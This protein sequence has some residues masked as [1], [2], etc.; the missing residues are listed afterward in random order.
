[1]RMTP[2]DVQ[3]HRFAHRLR[4]YDPDEVDAFLRMVSE[5]YEGLVRETC[6]QHADCDSA[7]GAGDGSCDAC[8]SAFGITSDDEMFVLTG[9]YIE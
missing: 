5:D 4:G 9:A 6:A 7:P 2:L 1:M 8:R 3:S